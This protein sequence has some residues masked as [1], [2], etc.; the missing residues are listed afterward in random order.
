MERAFIGIAALVNGIMG[1][2]WMLIGFVQWLILSESE[3]IIGAVFVL[4]GVVF[5]LMTGMLLKMAKRYEKKSYDA[6]T[7]GRKIQ[8][9]IL[10][11]KTID[12]VRINQKHP[13]VI[14]CEA[15]GRV[16]ESDYF[17][18]DIHRFDEKEKIDVYLDEDTDEYYVDLK[19]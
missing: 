19:S 10:E 1:I 12:A 2:I 13:Y 15:E 9:H 17:Y 16:F 3:K 18:K 5:L 7:N 14:L 6:M 11:V 4:I 8:A